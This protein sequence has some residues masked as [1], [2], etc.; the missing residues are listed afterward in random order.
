MADG[1]VAVSINVVQRPALISLAIIDR[2]SK[3]INIEP[4]DFSCAYNMRYVSLRHV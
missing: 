1:Q 3:R 4:R 2:C